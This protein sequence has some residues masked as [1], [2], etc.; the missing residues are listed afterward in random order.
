[1]KN[2]KDRIALLEQKLEQLTALVQ[3][4]QEALQMQSSINQELIVRII[5]NKK[6]NVLKSAGLGSKRVSRGPG[7]REN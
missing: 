6:P 3:V 2:D 1:M 7:D 5:S 4:H